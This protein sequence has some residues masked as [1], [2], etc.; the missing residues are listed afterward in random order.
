ML[1]IEA[2]ELKTNDCAFLFGYLTLTI[3]SLI[4]LNSFFHNF[5]KFTQHYYKFQIQVFL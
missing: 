3:S 2:K 5:L 4:F 1:N